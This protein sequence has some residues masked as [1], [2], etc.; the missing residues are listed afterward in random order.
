MYMGT[1][2]K[3]RYNGTGSQLQLLYINLFLILTVCDLCRWAQAGSTKIIALVPSNNLSSSIAEITLSLS[4]GLSKVL[5]QTPNNGSFLIDLDISA[6]TSHLY[7]LI[8]FVYNQIEQQGF[9]LLFS[10]T[11]FIFYSL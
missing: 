4:I 1:S 3:H 2:W 8:T 10:I 9:A 7:R 6:S 5:T 11:S